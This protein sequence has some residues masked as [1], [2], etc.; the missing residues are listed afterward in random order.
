MR[1]CAVRDG[2]LLFVNNRFRKPTHHNPLFQLLNLAT[3]RLDTQTHLIRFM[4]QSLVVLRVHLLRFVIHDLDLFTADLFFFNFF[5]SL[6]L[7]FFLYLDIDFGIFLIL[8]Y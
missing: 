6:F 2:L 4:F 1:V 5:E 7:Q 8:L 3:L